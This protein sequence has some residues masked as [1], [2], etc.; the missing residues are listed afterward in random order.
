MRIVDVCAFYTPH[1]G[2]VKTYVERK[3]RAGP[4]AGHEI[5]ILVPGEKS[6][7]QHHGSGARIVS[8]PAPRF[9]LDRRYRYFDDESALHDAL[10]RLR[11]DLVEASSPWGS[12]SMVARWRG[13]APRSL[14]MHA[15]PLAAYPYRWFGGVADRDRIDRHFDWFWRHLRRLDQSYDIVVSASNDLAERLRSGGL[16]KVAT[17]PMGVGPGHFSPR[18]RDEALR[19]HMLAQCGLDPDATLLIGLGRLAAEKRWPMVIEAVTAAGYERPVGLLLLGS[20]R[21]EPKLLRAIGN[22]PHICL[23]QAVTDRERLARL[24]ASADALIHG[25]EAETF[26]M[27]AAEARASGLPLIVPDMGGASDQFRE[28]QGMRY[29]AANA[30]SL[31]AAITAFIDADPGRQRAAASA[32]ALHVR[33]MDEHFAD[34]F[35]IYHESRLEIS[36]AA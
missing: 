3:L 1:G 8:L 26:C 30:S 23:A 19:A 33:T 4:A 16:G 31:A 18:L 11:P 13:N 22:N 10:N 14:V 24:L 9:P 34:L 27:V 15:D 28:G 6:G 20:G 35:G 2:G 7:V 5:I 36:N 17:I 32:D 25:C 21:D 12:A 29:E